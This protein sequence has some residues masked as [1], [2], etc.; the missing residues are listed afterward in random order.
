VTSIPNRGS[1]TSMTVSEPCYFS[2]ASVDGTGQNFNLEYD[3][4]LIMTT[5]NSN[6]DVILNVVILNPDIDYENA[7][8]IGLQ[9]AKENNTKFQG[10]G[11]YGLANN[12][13]AQ[14]LN[15]LTKLNKV[16]AIVEK[17][18]A[19][20]GLDATDIRCQIIPVQRVR[21]KPPMSMST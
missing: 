4:S 9:V 7:F 12:R 8:K 1:V 3:N 13:E 11:V 2:S 21:D 18:K 15:F 16:N 20:M 17:V 5:S 6:V 14:N 10:I 19:N